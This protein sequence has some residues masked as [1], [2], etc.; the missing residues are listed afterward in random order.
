M[1]DISGF[2]R[3]ER[4]MPDKIRCAA[5]D[6]GE[7]PQCDFFRRHLDKMLDLY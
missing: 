4:E 6:V 3:I 5:A 1:P 7:N 2:I